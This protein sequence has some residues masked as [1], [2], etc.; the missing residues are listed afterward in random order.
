[1]SRSL[2][3]ISEDLCIEK[4]FVYTKIHK[5]RWKLG[6]ICPECSLGDRLATVTG[7]PMPI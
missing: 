4:R 5:D 3:S 7:K 2:P 1:M 6:T